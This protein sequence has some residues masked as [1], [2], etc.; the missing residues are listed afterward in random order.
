MIKNNYKLII[1][2]LLITFL[3]VGIWF[4]MYKKF[5]SSLASIKNSYVLLYADQ[6]LR[7]N[8]NDIR[9]TYEKIKPDIDKVNGYFI[10]KEDQISFIENVENLAK[11]NNLDIEIGNITVEKN[12]DLVKNDLEYLVLKINTVGS[13]DGNYRFLGLLET[14]PYHLFIKRMS[15]SLKSDTEKNAVLKGFFEVYVA[16][17]I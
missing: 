16:K 15:I 13:W 9:S 6:R 17:K 2:S 5:S 11:K 10:T 8:I 3:F 12:T 1:S 4:L 7:E 14:M